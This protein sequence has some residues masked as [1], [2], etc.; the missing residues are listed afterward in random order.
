MNIGTNV[1]DVYSTIEALLIVHNF[2]E[3]RCDDPNEIPH[4]N[5]AEDDDVQE[6][7]DEA[8]G[9]GDRVRDEDGDGMMHA[10]GVYRRKL[11]VRHYIE[12]EE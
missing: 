8:F 1:D 5:G 7:L 9:G 4:F 10:L 6:V 3:I 2:L 11:L 12:G